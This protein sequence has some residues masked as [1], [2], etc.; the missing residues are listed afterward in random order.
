MALLCTYTHTQVRY[1]YSLGKRHEHSTNHISQKKGLD[2]TN[3]ISATAVLMVYITNLYNKT[4]MSPDHN[5][6]VMTEPKS[7]YYS[8]QSEIS[9]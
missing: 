8:W 1:C 7:Y 3:C 9:T 2:V 5:M 4:K 6:R